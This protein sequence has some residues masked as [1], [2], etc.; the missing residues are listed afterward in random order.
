MKD[1][2]LEQLLDDET[3]QQTR[4]WLKELS[5]YDLMLFNR[6][7][8]LI[9]EMTLLNILQQKIYKRTVVPMDIHFQTR[10]HGKKNIVGLET[11]DE[12]VKA[13][14][15]SSSYAH[16]AQQLKEFVAEKDKARSQLFQMNNLYRRQDLRGLEKFL[17]DSPMSQQQKN[18][19]LIQR[20]DAWMKQLPFLFIEQSTFVAV[21]ALHL[22]GEHGLVRLL[23]NAGFT[24]RPLP[25]R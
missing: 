12:Q 21:G 23:R 7:S 2:T 24:V 19:L 6:F 9:V 25:L 16:Q 3:F 17:A 8:P 18:I 10:A 14:F 22:S 4:D 20:N 15:G 11:F 1:T 13:L 5:G